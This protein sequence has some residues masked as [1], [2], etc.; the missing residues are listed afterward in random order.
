MY[1]SRPH[2]QHVEES[3]TPSLV[4]PY[5]TEVTKIKKN[6]L[7]FSGCYTAYVVELPSP[8]RDRDRSPCEHEVVKAYF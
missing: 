8:R 6:S 1:T 2:A 5:V 3:I 4:L 7:G